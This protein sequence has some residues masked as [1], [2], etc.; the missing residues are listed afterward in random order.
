MTKNPALY[1]VA[2]AMLLLLAA[3]CVYGFLASSELADATAGFKIIYATVGLGC[4]SGSAAL[5]ARGARK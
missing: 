4:L 1:F 5:I 3:F 2:G